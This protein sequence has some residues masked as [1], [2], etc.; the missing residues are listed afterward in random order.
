MTTLP[1]IE[2]EVTLRPWRSD[3]AGDLHRAMQDPE[4]DRW[5][6][7]GEPYTLEDA[8][9]FIERT[10][11]R[12][13]QR[14]AAHFVVEV[15]GRLAG[16]L[17]VL[18]VDGGTWELVYWTLP[19]CRGAGVA[20]RGVATALPWIA[21]AIAPVRLEAGMLAGNTASAAVV[22]ANGFRLDEVRRDT[23]VLDGAPHDEEIYVRR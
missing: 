16:Y 14:A 9:R 11:E 6:G 18:N 15:E 10:A 1:T 8:S 19:E 4:I 13:A 5:L 3:D 21:D 23:G 22:T 2:E 20:R 17:G 12:W 7:D